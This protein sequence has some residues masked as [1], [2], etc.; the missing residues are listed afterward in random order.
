LFA[1]YFCCDYLGIFCSKAP[2]DFLKS[3]NNPKWDTIHRLQDLGAIQVRRFV[4]FVCSTTAFFVFV[5]VFRSLLLGYPLIQINIC[6]LS[7]FLKSLP[8]NICVLL[9][10]K[11]EK[12]KEHHNKVVY[13]CNFC[14]VVVSLNCK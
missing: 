4:T 12:K 11:K 13:C 7:F 14:T 6:T 2:I 9:K 5:F 8:C 1:P 10:S 3:W